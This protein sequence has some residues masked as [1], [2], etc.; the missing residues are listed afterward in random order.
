MSCK[1]LQQSSSYAVTMTDSLGRSY[2]LTI[3]QGG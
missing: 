1:A 2:S 3:K